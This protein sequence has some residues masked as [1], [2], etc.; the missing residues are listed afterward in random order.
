[1]STTMCAKWSDLSEIKKQQH[2][3]QWCSSCQVNHN[4][5][6]TPVDQS[7]VQ[8]TRF[9][10]MQYQVNYKTPVISFLWK[11][12]SAKNTGEADAGNVK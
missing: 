4:S 1:M 9:T 7:I 11:M 3:L 12:K 5:I 8:N 6:N 10:V 2:I